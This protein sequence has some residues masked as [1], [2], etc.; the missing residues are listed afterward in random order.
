[1]PRISIETRMRIIQLRHR[2]Y[3]MKM[4]QKRLSEENIII[5]LTALYNLFQKFRKHGIVI[6]L[7]RDYE[8]YKKLTAEQVQYIDQCMR[9]NDELTGRKLH[10]LLLEKWPDLIV[11]INTVKR[12]KR[13]LGWVA[14]R[15]KY[16]QMIRELNKEKRLNW[17]IEMLQSNEKF[18]NVIFSDECSVQLDNHG[19]LCFRK[20]GEP[21]K[22]KPK[23]KHPIKVHIW[24]GISTKGATPI[25]IF[26]G[27]M[28]AKDYC[29]ILDQVL[30]PFANNAFPNGFRFQQDNDP[31][32]T[33]KYAKQYYL[34]NDINWWKT[35]AESPDL[36]PIEN[37]WA[38]L[39]YYLRH[40]YKPTNL[41][42]LELGIK[43]FWKSMTPKH[44]RTY[45][46]HIHK[47]IP[48]VIEL[49]G[50]PSGY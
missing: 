6:N 29:M 18:K 43:A 28:K 45:I 4:I 20:R 34:D 19:T 10:A 46:K 1:M 14:S 21:R 47:V 44:C 39:K 40:E 35:P 41:E 23:P 38:S 25:C 27:T 24:A 22:L 13:L 2:G 8:I 11:S 31:K 37:V 48:K 7:V 42:T 50:D 17:C 16:C 15:P 12:E 33:S 26:T 3:T 49:K 36:N 5:S 30:K 9:E 32:H